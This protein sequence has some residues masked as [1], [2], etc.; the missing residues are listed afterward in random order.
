MTNKLFKN[1][2]AVIVLFHFYTHCKAQNSLFIKFGAGGGTT[3][4]RISNV[5][6]EIEFIETRFSPI[7]RIIH[8]NLGIE[9]K[10]A[11]WVSSIGTYNRVNNRS[12]ITGRRLY[13][14]VLMGGRS[15]YKKKHSSIYLLGGLGYFYF[16]NTTNP[17]PVHYIQI[18]DPDGSLINFTLIRSVRDITN[19]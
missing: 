19:S 10:N 9:A 16:L 4:S 2:L 5:K 6:K 13:N 3:F 7:G 12:A 15:I 18:I 11:N 1:F 17:N 8:Y 14:L